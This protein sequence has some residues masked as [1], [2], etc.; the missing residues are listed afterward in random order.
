MNR[1]WGLIGCLLSAALVL[2]GCDSRQRPPL[3]HTSGIIRVDG[4]K[5]KHGYVVFI[6]DRSAGTVGPPAR[7]I[8][9]NGLFP[10]LSTFDDRDG[11]VVGR[12]RV[13]IYVFDSPREGSPQ[14]LP[15]RFNTATT[16]TITVQPVERNFHE[17]ELQTGPAP[18]TQTQASRPAEPD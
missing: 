3:A 2:V 8:I 10:H 17:W 16:L 18:A 14:L 5:V 11:A 13:C 7:G 6:P 1:S 9:K 12:H 15:A 4:Q